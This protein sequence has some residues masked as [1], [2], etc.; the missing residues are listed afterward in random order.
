M[1]EHNDVSTSSQF[2]TICKF[3]T[4]KNK[5]STEVARF[6]CPSGNLI[7]NSTIDD[8]PSSHCWSVEAVLEGSGVSAAS[9]ASFALKQNDAT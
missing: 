8:F 7:L 9:L 5:N 3:N 6:T 4:I 1:T 2:E